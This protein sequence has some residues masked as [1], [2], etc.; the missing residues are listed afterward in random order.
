VTHVHGHLSPPP[1]EPIRQTAH[2]AGGG[3][4]AIDPKWVEWT[5]KSEG[6]VRVVLDDIDVTLLRKV[7]GI[8][9][10]SRI[11]CFLGFSYD[12]GN[13][14]KLGF[15][16]EQKELV[17]VFGSAFDLKDAQRHQAE[18]R[19]SVPNRHLSLAGRTDKCLHVLENYHVLRD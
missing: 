1:K 18:E 9:S 7:H 15:P 3:V 8:I 6:Q 14:A 2:R 17:E 5:N 12:K 11:I 13:I 19:I 4:E 16:A 10:T